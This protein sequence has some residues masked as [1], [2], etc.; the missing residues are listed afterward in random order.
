M[1][2]VYSNGRHVAA[3]VKLPKCADGYDAG[4]PWAILHNSGKSRR[5]GTA[6][7]ARDE[8][9]K[10]YPACKFKRT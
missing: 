7:D 3:I 1:T 10:V 6:A 2:N 8:A 4:M 9:K 5:F